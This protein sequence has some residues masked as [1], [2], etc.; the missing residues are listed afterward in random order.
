MLNDSLLFAN[1]GISTTCSAQYQTVFP[2]SGSPES[3]F[4]WQTSM[5]K[6]YISYNAKT[7]TPS[8]NSVLAEC[9]FQRHLYD[10]V[11][12]LTLAYYHTYNIQFTMYHNVYV[13]ST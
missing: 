8:P 3:L 12:P 2:N 5:F 4:K 1:P 13:V 6:M 9:L 11:R 10:N 7:Q